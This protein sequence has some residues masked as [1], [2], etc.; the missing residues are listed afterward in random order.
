[1]REFR[2]MIAKRFIIITGL[3]L[4]I[5]G[6]G[7]D[8]PT[9]PPPKKIPNIS[10]FSVSPF[11]IVPPDS[12]L[13][14]WKTSLADSIKLFPG[15]Q[16][17]MPLDSGQIYLKPSFP[18]NYWLVAYNSDG[19]DSA[20]AIVTMSTL[21]ANI[22][23]FQINPDTV[24]I[25]DSSVVSWTTNQADSIVLN[26]GVGR[27]NPTANGQVTIALQ[28]SSVYR[29]IAFSVYGND[30]ITINVSV[31]KPNLVAAQN[32]S[33]YRGVMGGSSLMPTLRYFV[34]DINNNFLDNVRL[35]VNLI[36]GDGT[37]MPTDSIVTDATGY[38]DLSYT[39]DG[40][41]G[42]AI[43]STH[44]SN[45][46]TA[47]VYLRANTIIPGIGGQGQYILFSDSLNNVKNYNGNPISIDPDQ[48][49]HI[50]YANYEATLNVVFVINDPNMDDI[51][52]DYEEV[53]EV[54]LTNG[55]QQK[56]K[57]S[58]GIGSTYNEIKAVYGPADSAFYSPADMSNPPAI[59]IIYDNLGALF[60]IDTVVGSPAD[61]NKPALEI[62]LNGFIASPVPGKVAPKTVLR[63]NDNPAGYRRF[64]R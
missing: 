54:I 12:S 46:D 31:K 42:H 60:Y 35:S 30:T 55:Y 48:Q 11:D 25:G 13:A 45:V 49:Y 21:A 53:L 58:I 15:A 18:T 32:G 33:Y 7:G 6:C 2:Q 36:E 5:Y 29:A 37:L 62:H 50:T 27:L 28:N 14:T 47:I 59:G 1:M 3:I 39:F 26:N 10:L 41:L 52:Q 40:L 34:Q 23:A 16:K 63:T 61:T 9:Q 22:S 64:R 51:A 57:D 20:S 56:T 43:V 24:V 17:L 44:F 4:A 19:V 38:T 8:G